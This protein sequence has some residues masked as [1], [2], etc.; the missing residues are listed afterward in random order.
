MPT[1]KIIFPKNEKLITVEK[2]TLLMEVLKENS[3]AVE[4][5][6]G[7]IGLCKKCTVLVNGKQELS[8]KY[9]INED[10]VV[11]ETLKNEISSFSGVSETG[12]SGKNNC[13]CLDIGTTTLALALVSMDDFTVAKVITRTNPQRAF[14]ADVI[15]R[16]EYSM[17][18]GQQKLNQSIISCVNQMISD[19]LDEFKIEKVNDMFVAG[20]T[21]MLHLFFNVDPSSM[22]QSP[23]TPT[24]IEKKTE[25]GQS[26]GIKKVEKVT[27]LKNIS[28]FVGADIV[29]GLGFIGMPKENKYNFLIDLGT[30]AEVVLFSKD[31]MLC[32]AAAAGPCFEG[33]NI[34]C[35]MSATVGAISFFDKN[36][37]KTIGEVEPKGI[38]GTGLIDT[39]AY[40]IKQGIVDESGYMEEDFYLSENVYLSQK[41]IRQFQLAKSAVFSAVMALMNQANVSFD[42]IDTIYI[43][44][45][46]STFINVD[47]AIVTGLLPS[48]K[49]KIKAINNS[50]LSGLINSVIKNDDYSKMVEN[51]KYIDLSK[52][53]VFSDLFV[54][55]M[56][57]EN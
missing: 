26:L 21:T 44:G 41:D 19:I 1:V 12:K 42:E 33:A 34:E 8:C 48:K 29:S 56:M 16:I 27:S 45:G 40:L 39:I 32:T 20:N 36:G 55:N 30:N 35:G 14:G 22:G 38:C 15:S 52:D 18:N 7:G 57:F 4:H 3:T 54:E 6:C 31:K 13:L 17:K 28:A 53:K 2:G 10:I 51:A 24:F 23:Y 49:E 46:F 50:S 47:N 25:T 9:I 11:E 43:S 5:L 37:Y